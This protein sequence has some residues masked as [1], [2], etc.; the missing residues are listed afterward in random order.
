MY[1][2]VCMYYATINNK[3]KKYK[4]TWN[5]INIFVDRKAVLLIIASYYS[6]S[7]NC[8][9]SFMGKRTLSFFPLQ[10]NKNILSLVVLHTAGVNLLRSENL[11]L[12]YLYNS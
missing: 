5:R 11:I 1:I 8:K 6:T 10:R 2:C 3:F 4:D 12:F 9:L 7:Y